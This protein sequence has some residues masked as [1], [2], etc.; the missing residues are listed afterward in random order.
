MKNSFS[1]TALSATLLGALATLAMPGRTNAQSLARRIDS[2][3][4]GR[5]QFTFTA[6]SGVC[7]NGRSYIQAGTNNYIGNFYGN[8]SD[9]LRSDPCVPGPVRVVIDRA[10]RD[11]ISLDTYV[12]PVQR[13]PGASDLGEV[14]ASDAS[15][16]LLGLAAR[17]EGAAA[18]QAI[19]PAMLAEGA[20]PT[21]QLLDIMR[22]QDR[23]REVRRS[24]MSWLVRAT[25]DDATIPASV[26]NALLTIAR[27]E[28]DNQEVRRNALAVMSR[29]EHGA[30]IPPLIELARAADNSWLARES[31]SVLARSGDPRA[32]DYLRSAVRRSDLPDE[33]L[34]RAIR[35]LGTEYATSQDAGLLRDIYPRLSGEKSRDAV[36]QSV[37]EMGGSEN[38]RWLMSL[39]RDESQTINTRRRALQYA[40]R[41]GVPIADLVRLYDTTTD[42]NMK[43]ALIG[44]YI[45][46][47][48]R[49]AIDKLMSIAK[50]EE[51]TTL[52]RRTISSLSRSE[53]PRV[54]DFLR[55]LV[56]R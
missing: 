53:D 24:A 29:L 38:S 56:E 42:P 45:Q 55:D 12:G 6:R 46:N 23:P 33:T 34:A 15:D 54:K 48:E 17:G 30:G 21:R 19:M 37:A 44:L 3:P 31:M 5:V 10:G 35:G 43:E 47:G 2:A 18:R 1:Q 9:Q 11:I 7:G 4:D 25:E 41:A 51:N 28:T 36:L 40:S 49:A 52:R 32:R 14:R 20:S 27:D 22:D 13:D 39:A 16:Y 8:M 50:T 26:T